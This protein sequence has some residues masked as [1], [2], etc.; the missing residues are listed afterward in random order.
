[1]KLSI[2]KE[3]DGI[4]LDDYQKRNIIR[5]IF[6][7]V[8][9]IL[10]SDKRYLGGI[11]SLFEQARQSKY[12]GDWK[13]KIVKA[14]LQRARQALPAVRNKVLREAGIKVKDQ[15]KSESRRLV[16]VS[17]THLRAHETPEHL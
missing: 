17:Y 1:M 15:Q 2:T 10:G 8:D 12:S 4:K 13:S 7:G 5:D 16:P 11:N 3:L 6:S 9:E 14:Y